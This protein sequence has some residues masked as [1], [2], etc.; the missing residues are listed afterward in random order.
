MVLSHIHAVNCNNIFHSCSTSHL[1]G[2]REGPNLE[3][4]VK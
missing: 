3:D 1:E 2:P 4:L